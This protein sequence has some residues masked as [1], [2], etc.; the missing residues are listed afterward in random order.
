MKTMT[1][2]S[3]WLFISISMGTGFTIA[4]EKIQSAQRYYS[5]SE[6]ERKGQLAVD[7]LESRENGDTMEQ[8]LAALAAAQKDN[9]AKG[10]GLDHHVYVDYQRLVRD[11][12]RTHNDEYIHK[13]WTP[14]FV[15]MKERMYC[16]NTGF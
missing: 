4:A 6:C 7:I 9:K 10:I 12:F 3:T 1:W 14:E 5:V 13:T 11:I 16:R 15:R 8:N 2:I